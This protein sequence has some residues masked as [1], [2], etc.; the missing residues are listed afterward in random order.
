[1]SPRPIARAV[2]RA[3]RPEGAPEG[4]IGRRSMIEPR[5]FTQNEVS[6]QQCL[7]VVRRRRWTILGTV[8][9]ILAAGGA[10]TVLM[11]PIYQARAKLLVR[12]T[13]FTV[14]ASRA[15]PPQRVSRSAA[16]RYGHCG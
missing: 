15:A 7:N 12:A 10:A 2:L 9:L 13:A 16:H 6:L 8:V 14:R 3:R 11:T 1:M 4:S 5:Q